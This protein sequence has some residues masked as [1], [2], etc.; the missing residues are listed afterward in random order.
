MSESSDDDD[1]D[2][3]DFFDKTRKNQEKT[4]KNRLTL[5]QKHKLE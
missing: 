2:G 5:Y 1:D 3:A 4:G